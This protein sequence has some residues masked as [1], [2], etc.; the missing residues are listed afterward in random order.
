MRAGCSS[1]RTPEKL[2]LRL[3]RLSDMARAEVP[4]PKLLHADTSCQTFARPFLLLSALEGAD[5]APSEQAMLEAGR[6]LRRVHELPI[7]GFGFL[8]QSLGNQMTGPYDSWNDVLSRLVDD[9][10]LIVEAG[11]LGERLHRQLATRLS[12]A[13]TFSVPVSHFLHGDFHS[14][15]VF[16]DGPRITGIID[17]ADVA[18]G[19]PWLDVA[20]FCM[21]DG[22]NMDAFLRGYLDGEHRSAEMRTKISI[23]RLVWS[24]LALTWEFAV[25]G[26]WISPRVE[27]IERQLKSS[28]L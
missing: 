20:R 6:Q 23:Y 28:E 9:L 16:T 18:G 21:S 7:K 5:S 10:Q 17:W 12:E 4:V 27:N 24:A 14:R 15:H 22:R 8:K 13:A 2:I 19:D 1:A 26:D 11:V 25:D 3:G